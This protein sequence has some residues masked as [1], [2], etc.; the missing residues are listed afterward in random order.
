MRQQKG[1]VKISFN[2]TLLLPED[3]VGSSDSSFQYL[4]VLENI[5]RITED[6][7]KT[8]INISVPQISEVTV[9]QTMKNPSGPDD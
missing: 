6:L 3:I 8:H 1:H 2:V 4:F 5:N 9:L 7:L